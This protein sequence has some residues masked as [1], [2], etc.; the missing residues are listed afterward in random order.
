MLTY[1]REKIKTL[2]LFN[3]RTQKRSEIDYLLSQAAQCENF[4]QRVDW[5]IR[6][7]V[8]IRTKG[9]IEASAQIEAHR[10]PAVRFKYFLH[11]ID[12]NP[13]YKQPVA[14]VFFQTISDMSALDLFCEVGFS[15]HL[16]FSQDLWERVS[17]RILPEAPLLEDLSTLV[18]KLFPDPD[19][20][21]WVNAIEDETLEKFIRLIYP[22]DHSKTQHQQIVAEIH[23]SILLLTNQISAGGFSAPIRNRLPASKLK[24]LPFH[25]LN[26]LGEE[27]VDVLTQANEEKIENTNLELLKTLSNCRQALNVVQSNLDEQG[28]SVAIVFQVERMHRQM[29]RLEILCRLL[30]TIHPVQIIRLLAT[31]LIAEIHAK[32]G[33]GTFLRQNLNLIT[34]KIVERNSEI[35]EHYITRTHD[36]YK[37]MFRKAAG[38]GAVTA[39]TVYLK[40]VI[41]KM[42]L[43]PFLMGV[44]SS[45]NYSFSFLYIQLCGFTLATKQPASTAPV[46]AAQLKSPDASLETV[47][48]EIVSMLRSQVIA[49]MGNLSMVIPLVLLISVG[50]ELLLGK[51]I[52]SLE[53]AQHVFHSTDILGP[54]IIFAAFTGILL[55]LSSIFAGWVDNWFAYRK[56]AHRIRFNEKFRFVFGENQ[57]MSLANFLSRNMAG[58]AGSISLGFLLGLVPEILH[59]LGLPLEVRHVTL[60]TGSLA[61]TIPVLGWEYL[62]S[63]DALRVVLG[64]GAIGFLN[65]SVSFWLAFLLATNATRTYGPRRSQIFR[66]VWRQI[67][68]KPKLLFFP[69]K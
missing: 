58:F 13:E 59:F 45:L 48:N 20:I 21:H 57:A 34:L 44:F 6:L 15:N 2:I 36:E 64:I 16:D 5:L 8:W 62:W 42:A 38:G 10:L 11:L 50:C 39:A 51:S 7:F 29:D 4:S 65:L 35:G 56:I 33:I 28:V 68:L 1:I 22:D 66:L 47:A 40:F 23:D 12:R 53:K 49:I 61:A 41:T 37:K 43:S 52:L 67:L 24:E 25:T 30:T 26:R 46:I 55:F 27:F 32:H 60:A 69:P 9:Q 14:R 54:S 17:K 31:H 19:D 18:I 3:Q 63:L